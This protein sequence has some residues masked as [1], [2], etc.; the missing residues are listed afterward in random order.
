MTDVQGGPWTRHGHDIDGVT[1]AGPG[2]PPVARCGGPGL[3]RECSRDVVRLQAESARWV[4]PVGD[5]PH[6]RSYNVREVL[7]AE[8]VGL[9]EVKDGVLLGG[10]LLTESGNALREHARRMATSWGTVADAV[11]RE[12]NP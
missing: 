11:E 8:Y 9:A 4:V 3:C 10:P 12:F 2:R 1:V 6:G 5:N 7:A